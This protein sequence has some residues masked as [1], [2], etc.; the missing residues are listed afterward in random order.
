M[1]AYYAPGTVLSATKAPY[2]KRNSILYLEKALNCE[3]K[4][5]VLYPDWAKVKEEIR[6]KQREHFT[7]CYGL[8][9]IK[10]PKNTNKTIHST[11]QTKNVLTSSN[12]KH[13]EC[14]LFICLANF[15]SKNT[16]LTKEYRCKRCKNTIS[17]D[18]KINFNLSYIQ[19]TTNFELGLK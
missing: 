7:N 18:V 13:R 12:W 4:T 11:D 3:S 17:K 2:L 16:V 15:S 1:S 5:Y 19:I 8:S 6:A 14:L 9:L 10:K